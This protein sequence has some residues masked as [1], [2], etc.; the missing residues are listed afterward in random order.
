MPDSVS[1][2][3]ELHTPRY[4]RH[5]WG[6]DRSH[7]RELS[8]LRVPVFVQKSEAW[9]DLWK[10]VTFPRVQ[11]KRAFPRGDYHASSI[12]WMLCYGVFRGYRHIEVFGVGFEPTDGGEPLSARSAFE[13]WVGFAEGK[14]VQVTVH[15][16]CGAF[17]IY[18]YTKERT[19]Y[20]YDD[21]WRLIEER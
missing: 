6:R 19:P 20:H 4:L 7:F 5:E 8:H 2:Y 9:P 21:S 1:A 17:W 18:N 3:F 16:P 15:E 10:P 11:I 13:Y 14:G 12:D